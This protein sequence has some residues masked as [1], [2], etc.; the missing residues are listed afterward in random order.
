MAHRRSRRGVHFALTSAD[1]ARLAESRDDANVME[2]VEEIEERW[3][4]DWL[5]QTDKAWDE[6]HRCL[7]DGTL[8][9]LRMKF[10]ALV[11]ALLTL[12]DVNHASAQDG[13]KPGS[14][15]ETIDTLA[16]KLRTEAAQFDSGPASPLFRAVVAGNNHDL[17]S[18]L[19]EQKVMARRLDSL[20]RTIIRAWLLR[21]LE[22]DLAPSRAE[23]ADRL[24]E[25][26]KEVVTKILAHA[27][28]I[29]LEGILTEAQAERWLKAA[30]QRP[31][32]FLPGRYFIRRIPPEERPLQ[33][34]ALA[35]G[36]LRHQGRQLTGRGASASQLFSFLIGNA[37]QSATKQPSE[38]ASLA[39]QLDEETRK[40]I[41]W[42][43]CRCLGP[44]PNGID[45]RMD[46][47]TRESEIRL[48]DQGDSRRASIVAHAEM[49]ALLGIFTAEQ[50][51]RAKRDVWS[52]M[53]V[54]AIRD[55]EVAARLNLSKN[56]RQELDAR[57]EFRAKRAIEI[58]SASTGAE[59]EAINQRVHNK[60]SEAEQK[61]F[62]GKVK[63]EERQE[64]ALIDQPIWGMLTRPQAR[65]LSDLLTDPRTPARPVVPPKR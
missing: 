13:S 61:D 58:N 26:G 53:G 57:L 55:P 65:I 5:F 18:L 4:R 8:G 46:P 28:V 24:S 63:A 27:D 10:F 37:S 41:A 11:A 15:P 19:D 7:N 64:V 51:E 20:T 50:G 30:N 6:I 60:I 62:V 3:D 39:L 48:S 25:N 16:A 2:I 17:P 1:E 14:S 23:L 32:P 54:R 33:T 34:I 52:G 43:L 38:R 49:I 59:W 35:E 40:V 56:Q 21:D 42:W 12:V 31:Q 22:S 44:A 45:P 29:A 9:G 36:T 47:P